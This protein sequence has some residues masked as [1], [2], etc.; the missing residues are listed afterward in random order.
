[1]ST[2]PTASS[3]QLLAAFL[4]ER[5][6]RLQPAD[7]GL[8]ALGRR[9]TRGLRREEVAQ[10]AG[11]GLTWYTWLEQGRAINVSAAFLEQLAAALRLN[12]TEREYLLALAQ[13][14]DTAPPSPVPPVPPA[15][16]RMLD[17]LPV[18]AQVTNARWDVLAWNAPAVALFG[19]YAQL[20]AEQRNSLYR[21][22]LDPA[23]RRLLVDWEQDAR[24]L[25]AR[26]RLDAGRAGADPAFA[27]LIETL[28]RDSAEFAQWWSAQDVLGRGEGRKRFRRADGTIATYEYQALSI[29][30]CP[31]LRMAVYI[32]PDPSAPL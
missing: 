9:R 18:P 25:L 1:M 14:R 11:I 8:P 30:G 19:D 4:R 3:R 24:Q 31:G 27:A 26:F 21:V 32:P 16:Q 13:G 29:D 6:A 5:R 23:M 2:A 17:A 7:V 22:F 20:P 28:R 15:V 10:L 12:A